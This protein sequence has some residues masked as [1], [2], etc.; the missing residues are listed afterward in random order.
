M[1]LLIAAGT[2]R[3]DYLSQDLQRPQLHGVVESVARVFTDPRMGYVR[4]LEDVSNDPTSEQLRKQLDRWLASAE[5][6]SRDWVVFYYTGHG[7]LVGSDNLYLLTSDYEMGLLAGTAF[8]VGQLGDMLVGRDPGGETR[9]VKRL[10]LILDTCHS[11]A[12][13]FDLSRRISSLFTQGISDGM[14]YILAAAFPNEEALAGGLARALIDAL[15]D[16]SVGGPQQRMIFFDQLV[17]AINRR[18]RAHK[19][20]YCPITSP[21]EEPQFFPNPRWVD[22][23]PSAATVED[24]RRAVDSREL[25]NF[26]GPVSRGV[27]LELQPGSYF[28]GR[29]RVLTELA[30]WL[31][32]R[33]DST[34]RVITG[35]PG[36]GKSAILAKIVTLSELSSSRQSAPDPQRWSDAF[37]PHTVDLAI[38]AK[39]KTFQDVV[40]RIAVQLDVE[41]SVPGILAALKTRIAPWCVVVDALDEAREPERIADELLG[42]LGVEPSIKLAIGTRPEYAGRLGMSSIAIHVDEP[43]YCD[44]RD[45]EAYIAA[46]L[47][48]RGE[49]SPTT[50]Y[51]GQPALADRVAEAVAAKA[52]PN[53]L[54]ARLV[55]EELL[56]A[57]TPVDDAAVRTADFPATVDQAFE[58]YL[59]RFGADEPKVRDLL[60]PLA[61]AEGLGLPFGDIWAPLATALSRRP[62]DNDDIRWLLVHA[63]SYVVEAL[64][65]QRSVYRLYHQA[66]ADYLRRACDSVAANRTIAETLRASVPSMSEASGLRNW[67][68]A[69]PYVRT[70]LAEHAAAGGILGDM[71]GEPLY[72]LTAD[73]GRLLA[74][75]TA[76]REGL[77]GSIVRAYRGVVHNLR[78]KP[79][80]EAAAYLEL[81]ARQTGANALATE[82]AQLQL[83]QPWTAV[84]AQWRPRA[85]NHAIANGHSAVVAVEVSMWEKDRPVAVVGRADGS[86]GVYNLSDGAPLAMWNVDAVNTVRCVA[87]HQE[88][89][90]RFLAAAWNDGR[91]GVLDLVTREAVFRVREG[92]EQGD[93]SALCLVQREKQT[94]CVTAH[95]DLTLAIWDVPSMTLRAEIPQATRGT[96]YALGIVRC[97]EEALLLSLNDSMHGTGKPRDESTLRLWSLDGLDCVWAD[98]VSDGGCPHYFQTG[99]FLD[100]TLLLTSHD[101]WAGPEVWDLSR[102][103]LV[104]RGDSAT[105]RSWLMELSG[106]TLLVDAWLGEMI[107]HELT[108]EGGGTD[109]RLTASTPARLPLD[110]ARFSDTIALHGR[111]MVLSAHLEHVRVWDVHELIEERP[112]SNLAA[113]SADLT[114]VNS[115]TTAGDGNRTIVYI[116]GHNGVACCDA[117]T[118]AAEWHAALREMN[119]KSMGVGTVNGMPCLVAGLADGTIRVLNAAA[120]TSPP[121]RVISVGQQLEALSVVEWKGRTLALATV[122]EGRRTWTTQIWDVGSG[123]RLAKEK[124]YHLSAGEED[125]VL[126]GL[127]ALPSDHA[128]RFAF[129]SKYGQVM[130]AELGE[131]IDKSSWHGRDFE[132]W[133]IPQEHGYIWSLAAGVHTESPLLACGTQSGH[134][135]VWDFRDGR[136]LAFYRRAHL[137]GVRA[138]AFSGLNT[139]V[140]ASGGQDGIL[141]LWPGGVNEG[142]AIDVGEPINAITWLGATAL[143]IGTRRGVLVLHVDGRERAATPSA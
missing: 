100:R 31:R 1:R 111:P 75:L 36:S 58:R 81:A 28:T 88:A 41:P 30:N 98:G 79:L 69:Q 10:L 109:S 103:K 37:P 77:P 46:R 6:D 16:D 96:V 94:L 15:E 132:V 65:Q 119:V 24:I 71:M 85:P 50:P 138:V 55:A 90:A 11:G 51:A 17:P 78:D 44:Q 42:P 86:V 54:I 135:V 61:W 107:V 106:K 56:A 136:L 59:Q 139:G 3:Y 101:G 47:L 137:D 110:G 23:L 60:A 95:R 49:P 142:R 18:L 38:H 13:A 93:V 4:V 14:F 87:L 82:V 8:N 63:G 39:G 117:A 92:G 134:V 89:G 34:T 76:H 133:R 80:A 26:W 143:A 121:L 91:F 104:F 99:V 43:D 19:V 52:Y 57:S 35:G 66:L 113:S 127:A 45:L 53:F 27:E 33:D 141:K 67:P 118:G 97:G 84:W 25:R 68:L 32:D 74:A 22:G 108:F 83:P 131:E 73:A 130:V 2:G 122:E 48:K 120:P 102:R 129:A 105:T 29:D 72:L 70:H 7:E 116:G 20:V 5:R 62:Y 128:V 140:L 114:G 21:D 9:R 123:Q 112:I 126:H 115:I 125:K 64:D 12:G 40:S 124:R